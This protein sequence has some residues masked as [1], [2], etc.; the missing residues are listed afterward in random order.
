M[1]Q[2]SVSVD[3]WKFVGGSDIPIIMNLSSFKTRWQLLK[4][5]ARIEE[6]TFEGNKYTEFGNIMEPKIR[7]FLSEKFGNFDEGR[8]YCKLGDID[9]RLHTDGEN[10]ATSTILEIKTTSQIFNSPMEYKH[11]LVQLLFYMKMLNCK[12][13]ILAVYERPDNMSEE[14]DQRRLQVFKI[15][16]KDYENL[17]DKIIKAVQLFYIDL[18]KLRENPFLS[19]EDLIPDDLDALAQRYV[20]LKEQEE[21]LKAVTEEK[22]D[23]EK[24]LCEAMNAAGYKTFDGFGW[25]ITAVAATEGKTEI[26]REFDS[27]AFAADHPRLFKKYSREIEKVTKGNAAFIKPTRLKDES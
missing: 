14:F 18:N 27:E 21:K 13:G 22:R 24:K 1:S 8:H 11:Y 17:V 4:N 6:D 20:E 3:R 9:C 16:M 26:I 10:I 23:I 25:K 12:N 2:L 7:D 15:K 19:Q 5:K